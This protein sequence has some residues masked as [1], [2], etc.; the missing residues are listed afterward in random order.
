[1]FSLKFEN[2]NAS[3]IDV[4]DGKNYLVVSVSGINPPSA[5]I[6][7]AKS[8]NRK[9]FKYNGSTLNERNIVVA[10]KILGD[11]EKNRN[12]LYA[13]L[14]PESQVKVHYGNKTKNVVCSGFVQ[15]C[16]IDY[17]TDN[18][19]V[20]VAIVC[21]D[22]YWRELQ[23]ISVSISA[24]LAQ[25]VFPFSISNPGIPL[26]TW[27]ENTTTNVYNEGA[28]TGCKFRVKCNGVVKHL[29]IYDGNN[30]SRKFSIN[31]TLEENWVVEID[32][33][34]SPKTC[35]AYL[36]DGS[37]R[38]LL[39]YVE[40]QP[41]WFTLKKGSNLFYFEADEGKENVDINV[42]FTNGFLGV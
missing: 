4:N 36:P 7:T 25:F 11:V 8:P 6:F 1:M 9:G 19:V 28:E 41:T 15:D 26:S 30:A 12:A 5:S 27:R 35:K 13:W 34:A 22:P 29:T 42:A 38:N 33:L 31:A 40:G 18:E 20:S 24:V 14:D 10:I 21:P 37:E 17:F 32:T 2:E 23:E 3:I 39:R 16:E